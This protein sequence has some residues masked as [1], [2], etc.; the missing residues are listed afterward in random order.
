MKWRKR[1]FQVIKGLCWCLGPSI[2]PSLRS[3]TSPS[4]LIPSL[5][6]FSEWHVCLIETSQ[7]SGNYYSALKK[8]TRIS[9][10]YHGGFTVYLGI[11]HPAVFPCPVNSLEADWLIFLLIADD[12]DFVKS[13]YWESAFRFCF[14]RFCGWLSSHSNAIEDEGRPGRSICRV[15]DSWS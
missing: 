5:S 1:G 3:S 2:T 9:T 4:C 12:Q 15:C 7:V 11:C 14:I 8:V 6:L 13:V 10:R